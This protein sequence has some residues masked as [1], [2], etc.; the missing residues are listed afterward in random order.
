MIPPVVP[1]LP[2]VGAGPAA[3]GPAPGTAA[4]D[5]PETTGP[6]AVAEEPAAA[7][8]ILLPRA[9]TSAGRPIVVRPRDIQAAPVAEV[10]LRGPGDDASARHAI[11]RAPGGP[12][13]PVAA[14]GVRVS[15]GGLATPA[16][17]PTAPAAAAT[18]TRPTAADLAP[19]PV[20]P[21]AGQAPVAPVTRDEV[22]PPDQVGPPAPTV[23]PDVP[24]TAEATVAPGEAAAGTP[25]VEIRPPAPGDFHLG[26]PALAD[27]VAED[28][29]SVALAT[30]AVKLHLVTLDPVPEPA[31]LQP[32]WV[33]R[34]P[35]GRLWPPG[36]PTQLGLWA[37]E[38]PERSPADLLLYSD[39]EDGIVPLY[40]VPRGEAAVLAA[41]EN[42]ASML[43]VG[44]DVYDER[45]VAWQSRSRHWQAAWFVREVDLEAGTVLVTGLSD[46]KRSR[47]APDDW[48][49]ATAPESLLLDG[50]GKRVAVA[51]LSADLT[52]ALARELSWAEAGLPAGKDLPASDMAAL[53]EG[54]R[55]RGLAAPG[56]WIAPATGRY[57]LWALLPLDVCTARSWVWPPRP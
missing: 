12:V 42:D 54:L 27:L 38:T 29:P 16:P 20:A 5:A 39:H 56:V 40:D 30:D 18:I 15:V 2:A 9:S 55:A 4:P 13:A 47:R 8:R 33:P 43:A 44:R 25:P 50:A 26:K 17:G 11:Q 51:G 32:L 52:A 6:A 41:R 48:Q 45:R 1:T 24:G 31:G 34:A 19:L 53:T 7:P 28:L 37:G 57:Q 23:A 21:P 46:L 22:A 36:M 10:A 14:S 3:R 49:T 35:D